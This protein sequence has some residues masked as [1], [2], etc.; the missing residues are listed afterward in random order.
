MSSASKMAAL[1]IGNGTFLNGTHATG[2]I[3]QC[4]SSLLM[5]PSDRVR[6]NNTIKN[7]YT[8]I[9][10]KDF[11]CSSY[12]RNCDCPNLE[13]DPDIAGIGVVLSFALVA[14]VTLILY[15]FCVFLSMINTTSLN[16]VDRWLRERVTKSMSHR[17]S[18]E[19]K[20]V[21]VKSLIKVLLGL[22]DQQ[23]ITCLAILIV[24]IVKLANGSLTMYHFSICSNLAWFSHGVHTMTLG[25]LS[26]Y[27]RRRVKFPERATT[28]GQLPDESGTGKVK[29]RRLPLMNG[30]RMVLM[31]ICAVL[32]I[33]CLVLQGY[34]S[35]YDVLACPADCARKDL[36]G[37]YGGS[38]GATS[39][40]MI[41]LLLVSHP[42]D[43]M[44]LTNTGVKILRDVRFQHMK[45][46]DGKLRLNAPPDSKPAKSYAALRKVATYG[47]WWVRS[48][49]FATLLNISWFAL[50]IS[51]LMS[52][53]ALGHAIME[54]QKVENKELE[55]GFGQLV[56]LI[57]C[58]LPFIAAGE[59]YRDERLAQLGEGEECDE[60]FSESDEQVEM[61][62]G[63]GALQSE[64]ATIDPCNASVLSNET[65][66]STLP[67]GSSSAVR[68]PHSL[69]DGDHA[70][71]LRRSTFPIDRLER[72]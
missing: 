28:L 7:S 32:L 19:R 48:I 18:D 62:L 42:F 24:A 14:L 68:E 50:G 46:L 20:E 22:S 25:V 64:P 49:M 43:I 45:K 3:F 58:V 30:L 44:D 23:L 17:I 55:W 51:T 37:N 57:F 35:W 31:S 12:K 39:T 13:P 33:F 26:S 61:I 52:D 63:S 41:I 59:S 1:H 66:S 4:A 34:R 2:V 38:S 53:R 71:A 5:C 72:T 29:R 8:C 10:S 56:P 27:F 60:E 54:S 11:T 70:A 36:I 16:P 21:W 40:A 67:V 65:E 69:L 9:Q 6:V 47:W 15:L